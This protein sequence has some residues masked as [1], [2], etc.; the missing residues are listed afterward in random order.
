MK[1]KDKNVKN[2]IMDYSVQ[3]VA[4]YFSEHFWEQCFGKANHP[5][6]SKKQGAQS[7]PEGT[8][9]KPESRTPTQ[10][11]EGFEPT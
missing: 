8:D 10:V 6:H 3:L 5:L 2:G 4:K 1:E 11:L 9:T 7:F